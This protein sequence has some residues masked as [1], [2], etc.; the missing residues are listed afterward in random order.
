M[1]EKEGSGKCALGREAYVA[2]RVSRLSAG[3]AVAWACDLVENRPAMQAGGTYG[4]WASRWRGP[5]SVVRSGI[6]D[7][8]KAG[9]DRRSAIPVA[10]PR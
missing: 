4:L 9:T 5:K 2:R 1:A 6:R 7:V 3:A 8:G 10:H